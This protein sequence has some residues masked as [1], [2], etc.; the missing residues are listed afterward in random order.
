MLISQVGEE[1]TG[2]PDSSDTTLW[3]GA[4]AGLEPWLP[5]DLER[6]VQKSPRNPLGTS[7]SH[8][9]L[10]AQGH[11][12]EVKGQAHQALRRQETA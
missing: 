6:E 12:P 7:H 9:P 1:F 8:H 10:T 2:I 11:R 3:D 4:E 5:S